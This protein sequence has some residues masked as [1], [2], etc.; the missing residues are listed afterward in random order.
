MNTMSRNPCT[1][2]PAAPTPRRSRCSH[3]FIH[4]LL[5]LLPLLSVACAP[6]EN[7]ASGEPDAPPETAADAAATTEPASLANA[8]TAS[9]EDL[10]SITALSA[11][12][13]SAITD[14]RPFERVSDLHA[15]LAAAVGED[16]ARAVY[17]SVWLPVNLND[18][19]RDE[20]LLIPGVGE[21]MAHEF[22]EY[23]P[24][25][26]MDQFRREIGKYV[27]E[28][29]VARLERYVYVP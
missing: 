3:G 13:F 19:T 9:A 6:S 12:A 5:V 26:D 14:G 16:I 23:R 24:Y 7:G 10:E 28:A 17:E 29:E 15:A 21:R 27:D 25:T 11:E 8:N 1:T 22:E 2:A 4:G 18:A 20:I